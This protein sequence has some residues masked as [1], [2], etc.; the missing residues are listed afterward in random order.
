MEI[1]GIAT[2]Q[3][4]CSVIGGHDPALLNSE[5]F[6]ISL[7]PCLEK[8]GNFYIPTMITFNGLKIDKLCLF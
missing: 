7:S 3:S 8:S 4:A 2:V 1:G 6:S 5:N